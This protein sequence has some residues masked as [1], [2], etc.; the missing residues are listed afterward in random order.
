MTDTTIARCDSNILKL[1]VHVVFRYIDFELAPPFFLILRFA[2][3]KN[4]IGN[5]TFQKLSTVDLTGRDLESYDMTLANGNHQQRTWQT[6]YEKRNF[7][8]PWYT[9]PWSL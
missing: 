8:G 3:L 5:R 1:N 2:S 6:L 9:G 7:V 4:V